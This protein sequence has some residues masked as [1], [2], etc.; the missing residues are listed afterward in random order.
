MKDLERR[1]EGY[2]ITW[3]IVPNKSTVYHRLEG[4]DFWNYLER[5]R[6]GPDLLKHFLIA[7]EQIVDLYK[8]NDTHLSTAGYLYLGQIIQQW[9]TH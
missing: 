4:K 3:V 1:L 2:D 9:K 5:Q 7:K 8:P 6:M